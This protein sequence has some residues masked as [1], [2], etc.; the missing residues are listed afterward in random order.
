MNKKHHHVR[1]HHWIGGIL[2]T[3]EHF[4]ETLKEAIAHADAS[5]A[6]TVKVYSPE[7]ELA[8]IKTPTATDTYA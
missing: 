6:H 4:F 7:G 5:E 1:S 2:S 8:H 3:V